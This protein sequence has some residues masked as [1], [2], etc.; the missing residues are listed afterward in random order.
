MTNTNRT[1]VLERMLKDAHNHNYT[2][3]IVGDAVMIAIPA[4]GPDGDD[5]TVFESAKSPLE[6]RLAMG[7]CCM[8]C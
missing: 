1:A 4:V 7:Y 6:L 2:A 8:S 3:M 5:F